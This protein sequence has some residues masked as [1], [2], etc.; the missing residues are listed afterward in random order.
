MSTHQEHQKC[1]WSSEEPRWWWW[2]CLGEKSK[3]W[4][5]FVRVEPHS[6][7][8]TRSTFLK[9]RWEPEHQPSKKLQGSADS[10]HQVNGLMVEEDQTSAVTTISQ[11]QGD[12]ELKHLG[13]HKGLSCEGRN[14]LNFF[15]R[16]YLILLSFRNIE[17][18]K[19]V[20]KSNNW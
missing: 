3:D 18:H 1:C 14:T 6:L 4:G 10:W 8:Q 11:H 2:W 12:N 16:V 15:F 5:F 7:S 13:E 17:F 20:K 19:A 9:L